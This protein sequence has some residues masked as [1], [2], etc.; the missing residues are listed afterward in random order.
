MGLDTV[1]LVLAV[2]KRFSIAIPNSV[3]AR[4][5]TAGQMH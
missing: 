5:A 2:E 1:E 4:L 3:A